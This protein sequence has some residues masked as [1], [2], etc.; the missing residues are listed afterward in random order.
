MLL[1]A[2]GEALE[3]T[4]KALETNNEVIYHLAVEGTTA[5]HL[6]GR[7]TPTEIV[8]NGVL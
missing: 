4:L 3:G 8:S 5:D 7:P 6:V 2:I 1:S